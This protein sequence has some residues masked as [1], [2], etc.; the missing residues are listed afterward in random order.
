[1]ALCVA[2]AK[3]S[4]TDANPCSR[5]R[6]QI[7]G[8]IFRTKKGERAEALPPQKQSRLLLEYSVES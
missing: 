4:K 2:S 5:A 6:G 3:N 1:M 7:T 8:F